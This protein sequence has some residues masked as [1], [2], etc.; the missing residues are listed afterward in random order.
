MSRTAVSRQIS[1]MRAT[2]APIA[3]YAATIRAGALDL[4]KGIRINAEAKAS[5][6]RSLVA[7]IERME[8]AREL[9]T[10]PRF[11][12]WYAGAADL[13]IHGAAWLRAEGC[14]TQRAYERAM[15]L[16]APAGTA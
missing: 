7:A 4:D 5:A 16:C 10:V 8:D 3:E 6:V 11:A 9:A 13:V 1:L 15:A 14:G 2:K 12:E